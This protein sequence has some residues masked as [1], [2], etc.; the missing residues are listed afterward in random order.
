M[1][2][3]G[4]SRGEPKTRA[5]ARRAKFSQTQTWHLA[6]A[7]QNRHG[8]LRSPSS[9]AAGRLPSGRPGGLGKP[10][11]RWASCSSSPASF[12]QQPHGSCAQYG[13][14]DPRRREV[15]IRT[16]FG[17]VGQVRTKILILGKSR[18]KPFCGYVFIQL[19]FLCD[20]LGATP[21]QRDRDG[22][23]NSQP[24]PADDVHFVCGGI[25]Q[26]F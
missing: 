6:N 16:T 11:S 21:W 25:Q 23:S 19:T 10:G 20:V 4:S 1:S 13:H 26:M 12:R 2:L 8:L 18:T 24:V 3:F 17:A 5:G 14:G 9:T 7:S 22:F 15:D